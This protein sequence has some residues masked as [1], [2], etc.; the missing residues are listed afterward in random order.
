MKSFSVNAPGAEANMSA[1]TE[2]GLLRLKQV[3][4]FIPVSKS[5][6]WNGVRTGRFPKP[7]K[8]GRC[9]FWRAEDIRQLIDQI[10]CEASKSGAA[11]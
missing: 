4:I 5:T 2:G 9:T 7:V 6:F 11:A 1:L 10:A 3:L 8:C